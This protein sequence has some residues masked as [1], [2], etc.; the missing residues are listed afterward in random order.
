[1]GEVFF[2]LLLDMRCEETM[3]SDGYT[4]KKVEVYGG[5]MVVDWRQ[6]ESV[7]MS[8]QTGQREN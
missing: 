5:C 7:F 3:N 8:K 1:M 6:V 2:V 4:W